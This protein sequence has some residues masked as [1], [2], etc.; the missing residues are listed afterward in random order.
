LGSGF[1]SNLRPSYHIRPI[2][3]YIKESGEASKIS[4]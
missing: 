3:S 1:N 2:I 4:L